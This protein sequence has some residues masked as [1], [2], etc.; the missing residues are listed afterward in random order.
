[1]R[2]GSFKNPY[3]WKWYTSIKRFVQKV[4]IPVLLTTQAIISSFNSVPNIQFSLSSL[5]CFLAVRSVSASW[6]ALLT[7]T[8]LV[9]EGNPSQSTS[10]HYMNPYQM[11]A[12]AMAL[13]AVGEI[14]QD[15]DS[16]KMFPALGFGAKL[17]P[18]GRVS[19]E[20]PLVCK[21]WGYFR[22]LVCNASILKKKLI[23][24]CKWVLALPLEFIFECENSIVASCS[25]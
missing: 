22:H 21:L 11:N 19:H 7:L 1:M 3:L 17:P 18:D 8:S 12:Y 2:T 25:L 14:I 24:M 20:F 5:L 23:S 9:L 6:F 16:D 15:Y 10:L 4:R 13:K